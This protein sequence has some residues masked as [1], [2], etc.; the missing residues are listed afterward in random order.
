MKFYSK[1]K[2]LIV[3]EP[4][5]RVGLHFINGEH[6]TEN[7]TDIARL[8]ELGYRSDDDGRETEQG[9]PEGQEVEKE[10]TRKELRAEAKAKNIKGYGRM[11]KAHLTEALKEGE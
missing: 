2:N 10:P 11:N 5:Q 9:N 8:K 6:E 4:H 7:A 3:W 1:S